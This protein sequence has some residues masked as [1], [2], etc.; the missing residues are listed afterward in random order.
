MIELRDVRG[1]RSPD[2][3]KMTRN[4]VSAV[5]HRREGETFELKNLQYRHGKNT[6]LAI[7][8]S[9][10][11]GGEIT[12]VIGHNGAG[13]SPFAGAFCGILKHRGTVFLNGK[14][15][16]RKERSGKSHM[17]TQDVNHQ[18][19]AESVLDELTLNIPENRKANVANIL[20]A[21]GLGALADTHPL[22][23]AGI[24]KI[25]TY[26]NAKTGEYKVV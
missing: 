22:D 5:S 10:L 11:H 4:P 17:A 3:Q 15:L 23:E 1:L 13:K 2:F 26:F 24:E 14:A 16:G 12:A 21:M 6:A 7:P 8:S 9:S 25:K 20:E 19:F 18:R